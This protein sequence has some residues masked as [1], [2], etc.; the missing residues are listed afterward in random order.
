MLTAS[1]IYIQY[2]DRVL[3]D[4]INVAIKKRDKVGLVGRNGAG[5]S[6]L[7]KI[8][9]GELVPM[10]G[11]ITRPSEST[12]GFLHQELEIN[13]QKEVLEEALM[14]FADLQQLNEQLEQLNKEIGT[15]EDYES[16]DYMDLLNRFAELN[17]KYAHL[18]GSNAEGD[19]VKVLKGLGFS[20]NDLSRKIAEFSGGWQ[21]RVVLAKMLLSEP[22]FLLLDEP[23]NHL[24]IESIIW[25]EKFLANYPGAT[26]IISHDQQF[27]DNC[28]NRIWEIELGRLEEYA[29]N[30]SKYLLQKKDRREK[31]ESSYNNQQRVIAQ[32]ERTINRFMAKANKTKMAQSMKKQLDKMERIEVVQEDVSAMNIQFPPS[33]RSGE[34]V[35]KVENLSKSYGELNVLQD[36]H[37]TIERQDRIAFVGQNGQGKTTL[38]KIIIGQLSPSK[39]E[40][41]EGFNVSLGYYA[42]NQAETLDRNKTLL[43]TMEDHSPPEMRTKLRNILGAFLFSGED[44][45]KKVSVLSGG[46]R[47]RLALAC[48]LLRPINFLV[49]DEPTNHLDI[50]SKEI[51]KNALTKYDGTLVIVSHDRHFLSSLT[52]KTIEFRNRQLHEYLGDVDYFLSKR[53]A[54][55]MREIEMSHTKSKPIIRAKTS[56]NETKK[57]KNQIKG[58]E[59]E[60]ETLENSIKVIEEAMSAHDFYDKEDSNAVIVEYQGY[61][62]QLDESFKKWSMLTEKLESEPH[63]I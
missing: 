31:L 59:R 45:D 41:K 19:A 13:D 48:L 57:L 1:N 34:V 18:G 52:Q 24:D 27:L 42:Q 36:V 38:S 56:S 60:I 63:K 23:T 3:F 26:I 8:L 46:E 5:K 32:K 35:V 14:A 39:G 12:I 20:E 47:A 22:D 9:S 40:I 2:G 15:R 55:N 62:K 54:D 25:L 29:G 10:E 4:N 16:E 37:L 50:V 21:M 17:E 6:T 49:M 61:K 53:R 30:F 58:L 11:N 51:L 44:V 33:P 7:L 43:Q 28:T